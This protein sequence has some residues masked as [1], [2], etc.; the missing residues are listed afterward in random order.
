M[1]PKNGAR[2]S[3]GTEGRR[4]SGIE[5]KL[6]M[7]FTN[8]NSAVLGA[9]SALVGQLQDGKKRAALE[10][11]MH[12]EDTAP[13]P[14][15]QEVLSGAEAAR[16]LGVTARTVQSLAASG[17]IA[18]AVLPGRVRG[19]GYVRSSVERLAKGGAE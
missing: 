11:A 2:A 6:K 13:R 10:A 14:L 15:R 18:R 16:V 8:N 4:T 3:I 12:G 17:A 1:K 9:I 19:F 7:G 5:R